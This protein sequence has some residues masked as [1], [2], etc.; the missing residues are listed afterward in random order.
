MLPIYDDTPTP[1]QRQPAP[2]NPDHPLDLGYLAEVLLATSDQWGQ[3][4]E[5]YRLFANE[6]LEA[7]LTMVGDGR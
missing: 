6:F 4:T 1:K 5:P 2:T 3:F 7:V